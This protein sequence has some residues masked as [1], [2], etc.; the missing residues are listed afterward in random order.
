M[1]RFILIF[2]IFV[3]TGCYYD[4]F[5][6]M[7]PLQGYVNTC[8]PELADTYQTVTKNIVLLNCYSCHNNKRKDGGVNLASYELVKSVV[9]SGKLMG[10]I[11]HENNYEPMPPNSKLKDCDISQIQDW[12]DA[13]MPQ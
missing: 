5:D 12:I 3:N 7:Y 13:G 11:R 6:E 9:Q 8:D 10:A 1:K 4:R 2:I